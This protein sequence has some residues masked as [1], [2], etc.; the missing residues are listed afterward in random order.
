MLTITGVVVDITIFFRLIEL[1]MATLE[2][3]Y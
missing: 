2:K 3:R 1:I